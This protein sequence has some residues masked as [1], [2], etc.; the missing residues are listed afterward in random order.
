M[1]IQ[2]ND[3]HRII[4]YLAQQG[5][6][7]N[8]GELTG[9]CIAKF[10]LT[11]LSVAFTGVAA[12]VYAPV[13]L[14]GAI[15]GRLY[16]ELVNLIFPSLGITPGSYAIVGAAAFSAG[17]TRTISTAIIVVELTKQVDLLLPVLISVLIAVAIGRMIS[18][19]VYGVM[20]EQR[21]LPAMPRF[22]LFGKSFNKKA[23]DVMVENVRFLSVVST[24]GDVAQLLATSDYPSFPLVDEEGIFLGVVRRNQLAYVLDKTGVKWKKKRSLVE[25]I[26][27]HVVDRV[28]TNWKDQSEVTLKDD[29]YSILDEESLD[30]PPVDETK[31]LLEGKFGMFVFAL[32]WTDM[33][34]YLTKV[35]RHPP[36]PLGFQSPLKWMKPNPLQM[37]SM[38]TF[39]LF[40]TSVKRSQTTV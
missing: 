24:F 17:V 12:G 39:P 40:L 28:K 19:S 21:D 2:K 31:Q 7:S 13:F 37:A 23:S 8:W 38:H 9:L 30:T 14:E 15:L 34:I 5:S 32:S 33:K 1:L 6:I 11:I 36:N 16:G 3:Q 4:S 25:S 26:E 35:S 10:I 27:A 18:L 22:K 20:I 29:K